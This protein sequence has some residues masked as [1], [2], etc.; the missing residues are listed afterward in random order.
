MASTGSTN[1]VKC[2][3]G[4]GKETHTLLCTGARG[5]IRTPPLEISLEGSQKKKVKLT[6]GPAIL[7]LGVYP[8]DPTPEILAHLSSAF[9]DAIFTRARKCNQSRCPSSDEWIRKM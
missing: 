2:W 7:L 1:D 9:T 8:K 4:C 6:Y 3:C 5:A